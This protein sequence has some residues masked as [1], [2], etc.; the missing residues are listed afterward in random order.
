M[1]KDEYLEVERLLQ[2]EWF[3]K[4]ERWDYFF[5]FIRDCF[6]LTA[7]WFLISHVL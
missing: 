3:H 6:L 4:R 7:F 1:T 2:D 5:G